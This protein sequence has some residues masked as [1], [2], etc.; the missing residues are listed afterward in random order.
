MSDTS[1]TIIA[2]SL[3]SE[4]LEKSINKLVGNVAIATELIRKDF[5]DTVIHVKKSLSS[6]GDIKINMG[7]SG[8][9]K[10]GTG[11]KQV[12]QEAKSATASL[13]NFAK[14]QQVAIRTSSEKFRN[15]DT[16]E[17]MKIQLEL[18]RQ[19]LIETRQQYSSFVA[20]AANATRAGD[21]GL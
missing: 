20:M 14:A 18:L 17:T 9:S 10:G 19:R 7:G 16:L 11:L 8:T 21:E 13:D 4:E 1:A 12:E 3:S 15:A 5:D 2:A 6:I